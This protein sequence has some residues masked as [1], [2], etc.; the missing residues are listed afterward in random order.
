MEFNIRSR[1]ELESHT[2]KE[3]KQEIDKLNESRGASPHNGG[4]YVPK[5]KNKNELVSNLLEDQRINVETDKGAADTEQE[6][7]D[8][9]LDQLEIHP[10]N[11][12]HEVAY[13]DPSL[14]RS[15]QNSNGDFTSVPRVAQTDMTTDDGRPVYHIVAGNRSVTTYK[16]FVQEE[17]DK[18]L[19]DVKIKA[20]L[21]K[22]KGSDKQ[23]RV[24]ELTEMSLDNDT[25]LV[26]SP[27]EK[28]RTFQKL[29][30][31]GATQTTIAQK[32]NLYT[33]QVSNHLKLLLL[34]EKVQEL[35]HFGYDS[36]RYATWEKETLEEFDVP[37][38]EEDGEIKIEGVSLSNAYVMLDQ[39]PR[40]SHEDFEQAQLDLE[41]IFLSED[42]IK[43]AKRLTSD[44]YER[45]LTKEV[46]R[47]A[48]EKKFTWYEVEEPEED[49]DEQAAEGDGEATDEGG[50]GDDTP[51]GEETPSDIAEQ[52][53][54]RE[55]IES[56][57]DYH[58]SEA[59]ADLKSG[60]LVLASNW[61][62]QFTEGLEMSEKGLLSAFK[63]MYLHGII[64]HKEQVEAEEDDE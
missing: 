4:P 54:Q 25:H 19:K 47:L 17:M 20:L 58:A 44:S 5:G 53:A 22:Y 40:K 43:R 9:S 45:W 29:I 50:E 39:F 16:R 30:N 11:E 60:E 31:E 48:E 23:R 55:T 52:A 1:E 2:N 28:A 38:S 49:E 7:M 27:I 61:L 24:Q 8:V 26:Q 14:W 59:A 36:K 62:D 63:A 51:A 32:E 6:F 37:F 34:P 35:V 3:L 13:H 64:V 33:S 12:R 42:N 46:A 57:V 56:Q 41:D 10:D 15:L 21:R 18:E